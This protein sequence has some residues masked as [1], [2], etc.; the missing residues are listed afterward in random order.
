LGS[1]CSSEG[2]NWQILL[3]MV[4]A[5]FTNLF[6]LRKTFSLTSIHHFSVLPMMILTTKSPPNLLLPET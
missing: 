6:A 3:L 4:M 5:H 2:V 1:E